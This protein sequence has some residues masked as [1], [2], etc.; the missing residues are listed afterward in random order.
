MSLN[1]CRLFAVAML[2]LVA[3]PLRAESLSC[4]VPKTLDDGWTIT[5][6]A[7]AGFDELALCA[8][9]DGL[10]RGDTNIHAVVVERRGHL[11]A[12]LY[13]RGSDRSIWSL[14]AHDVDFGPTR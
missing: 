5:A 2:V 9:L 1:R 13:R 7:D 14:F 12:E 4:A 6:P 8:I 11:V 3:L 10:A